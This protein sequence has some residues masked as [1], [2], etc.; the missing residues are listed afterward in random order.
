[1]SVPK[2]MAWDPTGNYLYVPNSG[3]G[4]VSSF[5]LGSNGALM[6]LTTTA[7]TGSTAPLYVAV[8]PNVSYLYVLDG[9]GPLY[10]FSLLSG[11]PTAMIPTGTAPTGMA[12][13]PTGSLIAVSNGAPDG[14]ISL[15]TIGS[16]GVLSPQSPLLTTAGGQLQ[17]VTFY[18]TF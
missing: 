16:T 3:N 11:T 12:I 13:D 1:M 7:V 2:Y 4:T 15:F 9:A 8:S 17:Y 10:A 14:E 6:Q 5:T 18:N